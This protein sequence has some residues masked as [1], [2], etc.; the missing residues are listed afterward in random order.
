MNVEDDAEMARVGTIVIVY[1]LQY[2]PSFEKSIAFIGTSPR[3][4]PFVL[5]SGALVE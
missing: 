4:H 5:L 3:F 2:L 1:V